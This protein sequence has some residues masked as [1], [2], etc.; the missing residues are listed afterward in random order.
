MVQQDSEDASTFKDDMVTI[1]AQN[2]T[3]ETLKSVINELKTELG[4]TNEENAKQ[5]ALH[6]LIK[7]KISQL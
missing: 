4:L 3:I 7:D 5:E 2:R 1:K 6:L